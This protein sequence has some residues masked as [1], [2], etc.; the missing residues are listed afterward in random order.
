[1]GS[2]TCRAREA[3]RSAQEEEGRADGSECKRGGFI[4]CESRRGW[5]D[6]GAGCWSDRIGWIPTAYGV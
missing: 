1:M 4:I 2:A 6:C 3:I 5:G